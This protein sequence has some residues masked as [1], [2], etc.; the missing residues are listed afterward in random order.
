[1]PIGELWDLSKLSQQQ[2]GEAV[3]VYDNISAA[4][5]TLP[6]WL[7]SQCSRNLLVITRL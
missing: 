3:L 5:S 4:K 7:S 1:M 6:D 2:E